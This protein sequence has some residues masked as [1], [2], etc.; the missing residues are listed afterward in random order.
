MQGSQLI[1]LVIEQESY[2]RRLAAENKARDAAFARYLLALPAVAA[3]P[4]VLS[5]FRPATILLSILALTSLASTAY[6]LHVLP[7]A[8]TGL[9][10]LDAWSSSGVLAGGLRSPIDTHLPYLNA[11]LVVMLALM[12]IVASMKTSR[13]PVWFGMGYLPG[14]VYAAITGSKLLMAG[15]DPEKEL[16]GLRYEY[17]GA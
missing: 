11:G 14:I 17:R 13:G 7:P 12:E 3:L 16:T 15:V 4:Y 10:P 8:V 2:I 6:L 9:A 5:L 1:C